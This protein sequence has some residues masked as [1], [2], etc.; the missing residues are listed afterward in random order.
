MQRAFLL[1]WPIVLHDIRKG[2][3]SRQLQNTMVTTRKR[4][5]EHHEKNDVVLSRPTTSRKGT[6]EPL[7]VSATQETTSSFSGVTATKSAPPTSS[8]T[9]LLSQDSK[10][11]T[12]YVDDP[13]V[14]V[15]GLLRK[16]NV[17]TPTKTKSGWCLKE[18]LVHIV[19]VNDEK[20][21]PLVQQHG[22]PLI[23]SLLEQQQELT[24]ATTCR[25]DTAIEDNKER[26]GTS[27]SERDETST[28]NKNDN[29]ESKIQPPTQPPQDCF[30]SLCRI[31]AGQQLAGAAARTVWNRLQA[32]A[33]YDLTPSV[34]L[35]LSQ[36][37]LEHHL[38]KP[39]GLSGSKARSIVALAEAFSVQEG[40]DKEEMEEEKEDR[41]RRGGDLVPSC[42]GIGRL[43]DDFLTSADDKD[44]REA[45]LAV[46][47]IGPWSCDMFMMFYLER[48]N[49]LPIGDLGVRKGIA[50]HFGVRGKAKGGAL[51]PKADA[52]II[53]KTLQPYHPYQSLVAYY[54]WRVAD[55]KDVYQEE[56]TT[57]KKKKK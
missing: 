57:T 31:V 45:L 46:K 3:V 29:P 25:H 39:A 17:T 14:V 56:K 18:G 47:G 36:R 21:M 10:S 49:I 13:I 54:M 30:Q 34:I 40:E 5:L 15:E 19:G 52:D 8:S 9:K 6:S 44:V 33:G 7:S 27:K 38:Q 4:H 55:T 32:T 22:L 37:G 41:A 26:K 50:K 24:T 48:S 12:T 51:C 2:A 23:Y 1:L 11:A 16:A 20:M 42:G 28:L 43:S 53:Y 35:A